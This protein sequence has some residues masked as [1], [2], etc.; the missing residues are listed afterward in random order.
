LKLFESKSIFIEVEKSEIPWLKIFT[1]EKFKEFSECDRDTKEALLLSLEI[2]ELE[3]LNHFKPD[4]I[5]IASFGNYLPHLHFHIMA[6]FKNDSFF[7]EPMWG[8]KQRES[9]LDLPNFDNFY[10]KVIDILRVKL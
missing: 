2:I 5:N 4:K 1:T 6:R 10:Q 3:M 7:P 9:N 8:I